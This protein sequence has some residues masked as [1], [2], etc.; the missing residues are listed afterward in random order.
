MRDVK[1]ERCGAPAR[2]LNAATMQHAQCPKKELGKVL[3]YY[4]DSEGKK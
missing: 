3:P 4:R 2:I 1:C